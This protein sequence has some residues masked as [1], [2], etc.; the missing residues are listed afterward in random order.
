[1]FEITPAG[2]RYLEY[3]NPAAIDPEPFRHLQEIVERTLIMPER[4]NGKTPSALAQIS[5]RRT[6][7]L[8][9]VG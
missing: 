2:R 6:Q 1:V 3:T 8:V 9:V 4:V 5:I 7:H